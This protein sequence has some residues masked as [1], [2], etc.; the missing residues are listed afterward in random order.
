[1]CPPKWQTDG[2]QRQLWNLYLKAIRGV[3]PDIL[4]CNGDAIDGKNPRNGGIE[5]IE[6]DRINQAHM[7]CEALGL[8]DAPTVRLTYGTEYHVGDAENFEDVISDRL[9][10]T[11]E[12]RALLEVRGLVF[13]IRHFAPGSQTPYGPVAALQREKVQAILDDRTRPGD[14]AVRSHV[15]KYYSVQDSRGAVFTTPCLQSHT[16]YG[17]RKCSGDVDLG[18]LIFDVASRNEWGCTKVL[19]PKE[20]FRCLPERI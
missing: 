18:F 14:I 12:N 8:F 11:I 16:Q 4:I 15:H 20:T 9:N 5:T 13:D 7:A 17:A 2:H 19:L 10:A 1:L 6:N 3:K